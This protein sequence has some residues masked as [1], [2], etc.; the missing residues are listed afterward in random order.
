M[1]QYPYSTRELVS[2]VRH[3]SAFP[4][5]G[6]LGAVDNVLHFDKFDK[7]TRQSLHETAEAFGRTDWDGAAAT[8][9][10]SEHVLTGREKRRRQSQLRSEHGQ[11]RAEGHAVRHEHLRGMRQ[12]PYSTRELVSIVRHLSAFPA[13]G[14][15]GA[16]DNV[17][18]FDKFDKQTRQ[19]LHEVHWG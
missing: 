4:A 18:H 9:H 7:Q 14:L 5:D 13:D 6:L 8:W 19:S 17:L 15:L 10:Q 1:R 12:Y 2:I 16:V 3:L 11:V